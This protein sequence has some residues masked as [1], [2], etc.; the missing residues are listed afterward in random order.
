MSFFCTECLVLESWTKSFGLGGAGTQTQLERN[1]LN[2]ECVRRLLVSGRPHSVKREYLQE[3]PLPTVLSVVNVYSSQN[4]PGAGQL[5]L[6]KAERDEN[7]TSR[8]EFNGDEPSAMVLCCEYPQCWSMGAV[9]KNYLKE[10]YITYHDERLIKPST[11]IPPASS[12]TQV[13]PWR[14]SACLRK[15]ADISVGGTCDY[16]KRSYGEP[17]DA[18]TGGEP[19]DFGSS[20]GVAMSPQSAY[21]LLRSTGVMLASTYLPVTNVE[22]VE[23]YQPNAISGEA[24]G[25]SAKQEYDEYKPSKPSIWIPPEIPKHW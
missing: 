13:R 4:N 9:Q 19:I 15:L 23:A 5:K 3:R 2:L 16:C 14:C 24:I 22:A 17:Q 12:I 11:S 21:A 8:M 20:E 10:H 6:H 1:N 18:G 25:Y 7:E